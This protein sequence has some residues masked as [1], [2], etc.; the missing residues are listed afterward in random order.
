MTN[1]NEFAADLITL[2]DEND[3]EQVF[4]IIDEI[5][6]NDEHYVALVPHLEDPEEM[7]QD[8]AELIILQS[9]TE[10]G[11]EYLDAISDETLF[12]EISAIFVR[13]LEEMDYDIV[14][15]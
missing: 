5:D 10:D 1:E 3:Q 13:R 4:E 14:E 8:D 7:L 11:E 9:I 12:D 15:D 2:L 6:H